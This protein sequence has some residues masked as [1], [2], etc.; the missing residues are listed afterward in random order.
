MSKSSRKSRQIKKTLKPHHVV[1]T[2][3]LPKFR[4]QSSTLIIVIIAILAAIP[5][6]L[7][8]YFEFNQPDPFDGGAYCYSAQHI[9]NGAKIGVEEIPS[10]QLGTL[11]VNMLGV[12]IFGYSETGAEI[13]QT[14]MQAGALILMFLAMR[15]LFGT[16]AAAVGVIIAS[17]YLSS[18]LIAK[19]GNVKE[20][21]MIACAVIAVSCFLL[22][23]HQSR[24]WYAILAGA[25]ASWAP[26]FKPTGTS[27]I[28]AMG[29]FIILQ[30]LLKNRTC[31]QTGTDILLLLAG[32]VAAIGPLYV[33]ILGWDV[34]L[35]LPYSFVWQTLG[36]MLSVGAET[37]QTQTAADYVG[38]SRQ[39]VPFSE[40][41]PRVLRY[42]RLLILPIALAV[43]SLL[44]RV[45]RII[46]KFALT[47]K[48][49]A[50]TYDRFV[51]L[52][53]GW[54][55][56]DMAFVWIS[57]RSY[58][59]YYL[60][61]TASAAML[62]GY[63]IATY[64]DKTNSAVNKT[65]W[66]TIGLVGLLIMIFMSWHIFFGIKTS[67]HTGSIYRDQ[68]GNPT[69]RRGYVQKFIETSQIRKHH[70]KGPWQEVG[71]YIRSHSK[72]TDKIY[73]WGWYPGIYVQA[74]RFSPVAQA[75]MLP[76]PAPKKLAAIIADMLAKFEQDRPRF[77]VDSRKRHIPTDRPPYEL[78]PIVPEGFI[79]MKKTS[80]LPSNKDI[81]AAYDK[82]WSEM[83]RKRFDEDEALRYE[84][85]KPFREFIMKNYRIVR[86]FGQ[87]VLFELKQTP[88][89]SSSG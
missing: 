19:F 21:Y 17:I 9:L 40:Q 15:R 36:K 33:W 18:P 65:K 55:I 41:W 6:S 67:P 54:W 53:A 32:A 88:G 72:P 3:K 47:R 12:W 49:E 48:I 28:G 68:A 78:W 84:A 69:R 83:L 89:V 1:T 2:P 43:G 38:Q 13:I 5:F 46:G 24:W 51:L 34:Q 76:R 11:L 71:E 62:G 45:I 35:A 23:Q 44:V 87:H 82:A 66:I 16:L 80:F 70:W 26:L 52:L 22:Y 61:L 59:Q 79:G 57:P 25:F 14:I 58:E 81:I 39:L 27:V 86:L 4:I 64:R 42:Y 30:P 7:G 20:Q 37:Q 63:L 29:L 85:M 8:K 74:Q 60:P 73:V 10:A 56:L 50:K 77:I 31:K 75:C